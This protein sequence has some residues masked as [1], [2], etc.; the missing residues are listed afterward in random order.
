MSRVHTMPGFD[1]TLTLR[2]ESW[3]QLFQSIKSVLQNV[4]NY[5]EEQ[6]I[7]E[8]ILLCHHGSSRF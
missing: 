4:R 2:D 7:Q 3:G 8:E 5:E 6:R 1:L